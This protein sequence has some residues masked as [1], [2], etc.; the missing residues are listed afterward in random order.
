MALLAALAIGPDRSEASRP[1]DTGFADILYETPSVSEEWL[2]RTA[3]LDADIIRINLYWS[4]VAQTKPADPHD[5]ADPAYDWSRYDDAVR[6]AS[7]L[8]F[9]VEITVFTAPRWAEGPNRPSLAKARAGVWRP[10]ADAFGDFA[11]AVAR[12]YSGTYDPGDGTLPFVRYFEAWNEPNLGSYI[13]PQY[14]GRR[15]V[16]AEIYGRMLNAFYAGVKSVD[17]KMQVVTGGTA[18]YGDDPGPKATKTHP[19]AF[20]RGLLCLSPK[21]RRGPLRG[22]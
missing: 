2:Q 15:N 10:N 6:K 17:P 7:A 18:P 4:V 16:S 12:R 19:L 11:V 1:F 3:Q 20:H 5:P 9:D 13:M 22:G 14:S 8:G 21:L